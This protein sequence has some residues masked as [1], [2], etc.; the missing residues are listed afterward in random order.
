MWDTQKV[1]KILIIIIL[2]SL[3]NVRRYVG[4]TQ[5]SSG[6][7]DL[8]LVKTIF[9]IH[10]LPP[11]FPHPAIF[12][13][14]HYQPPYYHRIIKLTTFTS[15]LITWIKWPLNLI[16]FTLEM[17]LKC[18]LWSPAHPYCLNTDPFISCWNYFNSCYSLVS[19]ILFLPSSLHA[20]TA[21]CPLLS[22]QNTVMVMLVSN[23]PFQMY[24]WR[25]QPLAE[26]CNKAGREQE[27]KHPHLSLLLPS[28]LPLLSPIGW[29]QME[30]RRDPGGCRR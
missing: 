17:S 24:R 26:R 2:N 5:C 13:Y 21:I 9:Q 19:L 28:D 1:F 11:F 15:S 10:Y 14:S 22:S 18:A 7:K 25:N 4:I 29:I 3:I 23:L 20:G 8:N 30:A 16:A 12:S 6:N 27:K